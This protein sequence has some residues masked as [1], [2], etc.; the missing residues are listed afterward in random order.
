MTGRREAMRGGCVAIV[1]ATLLLTATGCTP[2]STTEPQLL[3]ASYV[4]LGNPTSIDLTVDDLRCDDAEGL[5]TFVG[6]AGIG[7]GIGGRAPVTVS[8]LGG[9]GTVAVQIDGDIWFVGD[10]PVESDAGVV[11]FTEF[12]GSVVEQTTDLTITDV[13]DDRATLSGE[14]SCR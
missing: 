8:I 7:A 4:D 2:E 6:G 9:Q 1:G 11:V 14:L 12:T 3:T 10:G 5:R 13:I